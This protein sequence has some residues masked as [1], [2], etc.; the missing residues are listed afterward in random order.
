M[1]AWHEDEARTLEARPAPP[2]GSAVV[3]FGGSSIRPWEAAGT[4]LSRPDNRQS[5]VRRRDAGRARPGVRSSRPRIAPQAP[6]LYAGDNDPAQGFKSDG[7]LKSFR[8]FSELMGSRLTGVPRAVLSIQFSPSRRQLAHEVRR[9]DRLI[10]AA[11]A[12]L[13]DATFIDAH[14]WMRDER[15]RSFRNFFPSRSF[16]SLRPA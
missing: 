11:V 16:G 8:R 15:S 4:R 7:V 6:L 1:T 14:Y 5:G 3:L 2:P 12:G 10:E 13:S 9:S